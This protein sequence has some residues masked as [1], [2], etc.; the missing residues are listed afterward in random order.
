MKYGAVLTFCFLI[1]VEPIHVYIWK[2]RLHLKGMM[3]FRE[4]TCD[5]ATKLKGDFCFLRIRTII[6]SI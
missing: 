1:N 5:Q 3:I 4:G 6:N 2:I